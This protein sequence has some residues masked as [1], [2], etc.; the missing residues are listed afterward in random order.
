MAT[1]QKNRDLILIG[2]YQRGTDPRVDDSIDRIDP[3]VEFL[4]QKTDEKSTFEETAGRMPE[5][6]S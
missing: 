2:A 5:L 1:Y 4:K 6:V 3:I